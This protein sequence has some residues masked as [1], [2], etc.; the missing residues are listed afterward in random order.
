MSGPVD[1]GPYA[2]LSSKELDRLVDQAVDLRLNGPTNAQL[3]GCLTRHGMPRKHAEAQVSQGGQLRHF[4][5]RFYGDV[6]HVKR[7][8]DQAVEALAR[9]EHC[10]ETWGRMRRAGRP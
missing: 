9:I 2:D 5:E 3:I 1:T 6:Q 8:D 4:A 7:K 10:R